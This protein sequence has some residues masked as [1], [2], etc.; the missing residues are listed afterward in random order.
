MKASIN[1]IPDP[2]TPARI[3]ASEEFARNGITDPA[4]GPGVD[5]AEWMNPKSMAT[6]FKPSGLT[7]ASGESRTTIN[8]IATPANTQPRPLWEDADFSSHRSGRV[9]KINVNAATVIK[10]SPKPIKAW[11]LSSANTTV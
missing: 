4:S 9:L 5:C 1:T 3:L 2:R 7:E 8:E 10:A 6:R 11:T